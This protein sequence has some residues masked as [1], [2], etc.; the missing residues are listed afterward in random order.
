M[1]AW[2]WLQAAF[3]R[4]T[5]HNKDVWPA[6]IVVIENRYPGSGRLDDVLLAVFSTEDIHHVQSRFFRNINELRRR[7]GRHGCGRWLCVHVR[8]HRERKQHG[9]AKDGSEIREREH[10]Q[11]QARRLKSVDMKL[12]SELNSRKLAGSNVRSLATA[13]LTQPA[14][15]Y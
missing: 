14:G 10:W 7:T 13:R 12:H 2:R 4:C 9:K 1:I 11:R 15:L 3:E 6:I 8:N 5:V